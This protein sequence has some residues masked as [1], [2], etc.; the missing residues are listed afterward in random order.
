MAIIT[1]KTSFCHRPRHFNL[2]QLVWALQEFSAR[3]FELVSILLRE[4]SAAPAKDSHGKALFGTHLLPMAKIPHLWCSGS[5][6]ALV[7]GSTAQNGVFDKDYLNTQKLLKNWTFLAESFLDILGFN[8]KNFQPK[9]KDFAQ[10]TAHITR[11][12]QN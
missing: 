8:F 2:S 9:F 11:F 1:L 7:R 5:R 4:I 3:N 12:W 6:F 10:K